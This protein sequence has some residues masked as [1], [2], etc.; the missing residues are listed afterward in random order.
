MTQDHTSFSDTPKPAT[1]IS[2]ASRKISDFG[3][4]VLVLQGGGALG[5]YQAGVYQAMHEAGIE[6]DWVIGTSI[7][8][9]NA[10]LIAGN[11]PEHRLAKLRAFWSRVEQSPALDLMAAAMPWVARGLPNWLTMAYGVADFFRP[12]PLAFLGTNVYLAPEAVGYYS[13]EPL[14]ATLTKLVD[15]SIVQSCAPRLTVGAANVNT[16]EMRYFD[17]RDTRIN[18]R[19]VMASGALP[20]A[21]PAVR[22]D[23]ELYWDGG[24]LSNT[25]VEAVF[26]DRPR[27]NSLIFAVHIWNPDGPEPK[28]ITQVMNRQKDIQYCSR[29]VTHIG[30]QQ[31]IHRLRHIVAELAARLPLEERD[32]PVVR[33]MASYGCQTQMHVVRLLAPQLEGEDH[34]KDIDFSHA[35]IT[36]RWEAGLT[37]AR[38]V[39]NDAPWQGETDPLEGFHLHECRPA[40][41]AMK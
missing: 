37:D 17:S 3:Q 5:A 11:K 25:P 12:N 39:L 35:G 9:I 7:G 1:T 36:A 2:R 14:E 30:R 24:I 22:I 4:I 23:G 40:T 21:F 16:A 38:R 28:T 27:R 8:A 6:P 31:Q 10:S 15:F 29:T 20:P 41:Q 26:D 18:V 34:T 33:E 13:T 19:H 32:S